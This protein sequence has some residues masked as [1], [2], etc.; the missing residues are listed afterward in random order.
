MA[1]GPEYQVKQI[2]GVRERSARVIRLK[3]ELNKI[4]E[5]VVTGRESLEHDLQPHGMLRERSVD[6]AWMGKLKDLTSCYNSLTTSRIQLDKSERS[7]EREM[8]PAE[9]KEA[10]YSFVMSLDGQER[11]F[12]LRKMI[13][14]HNAAQGR[15]PAQMRI[16]EDE[17]YVSG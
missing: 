15:S 6:K 9:E 7:M 2:P 1:R 11:G 4:L 12:F 13:N 17:P 5:L 10:V 8:T 3:E 16:A 14:A